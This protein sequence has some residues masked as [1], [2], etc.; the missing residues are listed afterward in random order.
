MD[1]ATRTLASGFAFP[2]GPRWHEGRLWFSDQ[3]GG[4]VYALN[5][6]G[7][8]A[9]QIEVPGQ[10]S[11]L[12]WLPDGELLVVS[13]KRR[14]LYR[15]AAS[16]AL[17][18]HAEL[19]HLHPGYSNDMVVDERGRAYVGNIGFD[20]DGG[21]AFAP[22][23][24]ALVQPDGAVCVAADELMCPNG[25][26][27]APDGRLI[28]AESMGR[29]LAVF[30]RNPDGTMGER[31]IFAE[32]GDHVPDGIAVD[33]EGNVWVASCF[34]NAVIR[35][36]EGGAIVDRVPIDG[37]QAY[38]CALGGADGR[39]LFVCCATHHHPDETL[40]ARS[41]RIDVARVDV[42]AENF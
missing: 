37:A 31:R 42:P 7:S 13:M 11:G 35:V 10:P 26:V 25:A 39:D 30:D 21:A 23:N 2:E 34:A 27:I 41:G 1:Y 40:A 22:T 5:P 17:Y 14:R 28:L 19:A 36:R 4:Y 18:V 3:H 12:G 32:L 15:R 29:R 38:A 9:E 20:F 24:I 16:G 33:A 8:V 6:D